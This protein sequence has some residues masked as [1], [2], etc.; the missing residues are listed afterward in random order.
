[1][2]QKSR[3]NTLIYSKNTISITKS[4]SNNNNDDDD[5]DDDNSYKFQ[6]TTDILVLTFP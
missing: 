5:D 2:T 4:E 1:M 3:Y 6:H